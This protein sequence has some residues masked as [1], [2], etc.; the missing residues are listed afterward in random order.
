MVMAVAIPYLFH[1]LPAI[2]CVAVA[3]LGVRSTPG[4]LVGSDIR[5]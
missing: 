1:Q 3:D 2:T 5:S 4:L